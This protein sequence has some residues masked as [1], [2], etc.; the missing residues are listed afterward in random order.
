MSSELRK[1]HQELLSYGTIIQLL[2]EELTNIDQRA[3]P[4]AINRNHNRNFLL[5]DHHSSPIQQE[6][7]QQVP[8]NTRKVKTTRNHSPPTTIPTQNRFD[9]LSN[10]KEVNALS[11][12]VLLTNPKSSNVENLSALKR[13][14]LIVGDSHARDSASH[15]LSYSGDEYS[16]SSF[17]K[18]GAPM[19]EIVA[20]AD[21]LKATVR[22]DVVVIWGGTRDIGRNEAKK[23]LQ[24]IKEFRPQS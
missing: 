16:V 24:Q 13:N 21:E 11:S 1:A 7:W 6:G 19:E 2:R 4:D 22:S 18:S 12:P 3:R 9:P 5:E 10:L 14:V 15:L 17:V 20:T 23:A 8:L